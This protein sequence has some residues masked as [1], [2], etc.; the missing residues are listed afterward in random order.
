MVLIS[1]LL[2][3]EEGMEKWCHNSLNL[4]PK[5]NAAVQTRIPSI[6]WN[7]L[8]IDTQSHDLY[9]IDPQGHLL[10]LALKKISHNCL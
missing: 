5:I 4:G 7:L 2:E 6:T 3:A 8:E 1:A 9:Y 10:I